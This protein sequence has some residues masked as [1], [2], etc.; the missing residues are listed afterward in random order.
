VSTGFKIMA[1]P[2][3]RPGGGYLKKNAQWDWEADAGG[4]GKNL[5]GF[6][7]WANY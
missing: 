7:N 3:I 5:L 6:G 1:I 4:F 2:E